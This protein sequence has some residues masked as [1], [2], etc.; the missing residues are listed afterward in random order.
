MHYVR[1]SIGNAG[2]HL[3]REDGINVK[4]GILESPLRVISQL[5]IEEVFG[6]APPR[7]V[8]HKVEY[9]NR[10]VFEELLLRWISRQTVPLW[11]VELEE[12]RDLLHYC[13]SLVSNLL[14]SF[15]LKYY[16]FLQRLTSELRRKSKLGFKSECNPLHTATVWKYYSFIDTWPL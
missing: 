6:T 10:E 12:F 3:R 5:V 14:I 1:T 7:G 2:K 13:C 15:D 16:M 4:L 9:F 8:R 11:V